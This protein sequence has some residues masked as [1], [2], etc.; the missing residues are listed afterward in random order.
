MKVL[1]QKGQFLEDDQFIEAVQKLLFCDVAVVALYNS[2]SQ[3][4]AFLT[5]F[6][7]LLNQS[8]QQTLH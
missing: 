5:L 3:S 6:M 4:Q 8:F 2:A 7:V 1:V